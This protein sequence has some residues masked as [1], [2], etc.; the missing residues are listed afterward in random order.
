MKTSTLS[1]IGAFCSLAA[2]MGPMTATLGS[3]VTV[4]VQPTVHVQSHAMLFKRKQDAED[5]AN[6]VAAAATDPNEAAMKIKSRDLINTDRQDFRP[7]PHPHHHH[8]QARHDSD[9]DNNNNEESEEDS[10]EDSKKAAKKGSAKKKA[11][12][13]EEDSDESNKEGD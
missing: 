9:D 13:E 5:P 3:S 7:D 4:L 6:P 10:G 2:A 8:G 12:K 1:G 11:D